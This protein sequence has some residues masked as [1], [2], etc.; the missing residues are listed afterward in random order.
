MEILLSTDGNVG[1]RFFP[2]LEEGV[3]FEVAQTVDELHC[4]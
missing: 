4:N 3:L 1:I 2:V